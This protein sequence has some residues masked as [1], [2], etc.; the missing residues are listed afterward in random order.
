M[1]V[2][3]PE[4]QMELAVRD[5]QRTQ[6]DDVMRELEEQMR[7]SFGSI[8]FQELQSL[9]E[10]DRQKRFADNRKKTDEATRQ[11][12]DKLGKILDARQRERLSQ[13]RV[14]REGVAAFGRPDVAN[15]L[16]LSDEQKAKIRGIDEAARPQFGGPGGPMGQERKLVKDFDKDGD[17]Q[18]NA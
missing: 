6:V 14:Q 12:D 4:V 17:Q 8:N 11:A 9:S 10:E 2:G 3:M 15:Q 1:M 18:L 16:G 13:L 5:E 7:A